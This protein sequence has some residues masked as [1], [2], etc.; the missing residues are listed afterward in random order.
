MYL[1]FGEP[2][3]TSSSTSAAVAFG[4]FFAA[5]FRA[6]PCVMVSLALLTVADYSELAAVMSSGRAAKRPYSKASGG[7]AF[8]TMPD[9]RIPAFSLR[10]QGGPFSSG[11]RSPLWER[12]ERG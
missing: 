6:S 4:G 3:T 11:C 12:Q 2:D 8:R 7:R 10:G 9:D 1:R 5:D